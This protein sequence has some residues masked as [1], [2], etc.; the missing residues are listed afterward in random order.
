MH[1]GKYV[2]STSMILDEKYANDTFNSCKNIIHPASGRVAMDISCGS[3]DSKSC[4]PERWYHFLGDIDDNPLTPFK[5]DYVLDPSETDR[6]F[7]GKAKPCFES[8]PVR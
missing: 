2:E 3:Y 4:T 7:E 1:L 6:K 8:Y 5:V